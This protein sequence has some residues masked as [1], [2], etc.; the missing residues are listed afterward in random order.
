MKRAIGA[1]REVAH[2]AMELFVEGKEEPLDDEKRLVSAEKVP[3]FMLPKQVSDRLALEALYKSCGGAG[4]ERKCGWMTDAGLGEWEGVTVDAE[5]RVI[6]LWLGA[7]N[8]EG[9]LPSEL[10]QLSALTVLC[11][12]ENQLTGPIP[13]ELGQLGALM[14]LM[15]LNLTRNFRLSGKVALRLHPQEHNP[16]CYFTC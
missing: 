15:V 10:Q 9:P 5:G 1:L 2:Y 12:H 7:N 8:L 13:A 14:A 3:L 11:L 4:W 16:G 6:K